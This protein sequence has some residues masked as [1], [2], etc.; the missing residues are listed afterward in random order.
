MED[1]R[2]SRILLDVRRRRNCACRDATRPVRSQGNFNDR[3]PVPT[4]QQPSTHAKEGWCHRSRPEV[5]ITH[6]DH[7]FR[8]VASA[9]AQRTAGL[10]AGQDI[11]FP[12]AARGQQ[13]VMPVIGVLNSGKEQLR[14]DQFDGLH[15]GLKEAA[16]LAGANVTIAYLGADN[17]YERL[18]GL[19]EEF[20][21]RPVTV[22]AAV[23]GPVVALAAKAV[24]ST[25]P[26]VFSAVSD[27]VKSGLVASLNRPGGNVTGSAG[28]T[29]ELDAKRYRTS[30]FRPLRHGCRSRCEAQQNRWAWSG[31][32]RHRLPGLFVWSCRRHK[33]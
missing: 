30:D 33:R 8:K 13:P 23:G 26:V 29:I 11:A 21:R 14:P 1:D 4:R 20:V 9:D 28:F 5:V 7:H 31:A 24:T 19:A 18:P 22:I 27:P 32:P 17:H 16:F 25:I 6:R 10:P 2:K 12:L 3:P 15:R